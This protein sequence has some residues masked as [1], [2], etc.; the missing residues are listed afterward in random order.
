MGGVDL[1]DMYMALYS[2]PTRA[3]RWYF[4]LFGYCLELAL[5]NSYLQYRRDCKLLGVPQ[6]LK[7]SKEFRIAV[8]ET[9]RNGALRSRG[10]PSLNASLNKKRI[11]RPMALRP[12]ADLRLDGLN[13]W[14]D[15]TTKGRCKYCSK[16]FS[17]LKCT[18]C[19]L[20][21]CLVQGRNCFVQFHLE[22]QLPIE[23]ARAKAKNKNTSQTSQDADDEDESSGA[24][25]NE[26]GKEDDPDPIL[27]LDESDPSFSLDD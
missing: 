13:H 15:N 25:E 6:D 23:I 14:P 24:D 22:K 12:D 4:S 5:T 19:N 3:R 21:L 16:G 18:K 9:L 10:R 2:I 8:S 1:S 20:H 7:T 26:S 27:S 17:R 11:R